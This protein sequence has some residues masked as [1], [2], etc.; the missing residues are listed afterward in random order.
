MR[1]LAAALCA[2]WVFGAPAY[3]ATGSENDLDRERAA[4]AAV[5]AKAGE[6]D[7]DEHAIAD[8]LK[9][10]IA[11]PNF[12]YLNDTERHLAY[13]IYGAA[14]FDLKNYA[15]AKAPVY[16]ATLMSA[17]GEVDWELRLR[18]SFL[19][20]DKI[21]AARAVTVLA[22]FWPDSLA[23]F[24]GRL[25][26]A[27]ARD[28]E[29][30]ADAKDVAF[31]YLD[32][33][34]ALHWHPDDP[35]LAPDGLWMSLVRLSV[36]RGD[37]DHAKEA[38]A[39]LHG[40]IELIV[41]HADKRYDPIVKAAPDRFDVP[42]EIQAGLDRD[43]KNSM[44]APTKLA[45]VNAV[46]ETLLNLNRAQEALDLL[47]GA[48]D[49]FKAK[50]DSF[51]DAEE[52]LNWTLDLRARALFALGRSDEALAAM[53]EGAATKE[54]GTVNVSQAINLADEYVSH[55][56][57]KDALAAVSVLDFSNASPYGRMALEDARACAYYELG[58]TES[59][60]KVLDYMKAHVKDGAQPYL[61][62]MLL[63][64]NVDAAAAEVIAELADPARRDLM[65][66]YLQDYLP[67]PNLPPRAAALHAD[68][69]ALRDRAD[70]RAAIAKVGRIERYA[71]VPPAY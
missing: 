54:M 39:D 45:G 42:K 24:S 41:L 27:I 47:S 28:I 36:E 71:L 51:D 68:W 46:A 22:K 30:R 12:P 33:L 61:N 16:Q 66:Y 5:L 6:K 7:A 56:R 20:D 53:A 13:L 32:A 2:A 21:D 63:T 23:K 4:L 11:D 26:L 15:E 3:A 17:A 48:L 37:I 55:D 10:V 67:P 35:F 62:T 9:T 52:K 25:Y 69:L 19:L 14:L 50:P 64:K 8:G 65:L 40:A 43:R 59:L 1:W 58:D 34:H 38:A 31:A 49:R 60:A 44:A 70:V 29:E 57:P 18:N